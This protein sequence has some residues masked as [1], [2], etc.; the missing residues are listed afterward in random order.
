MDFKLPTQHL[1]GF[2]ERNHE[3]KLSEGS[4]TMWASG[5]QPSYD[6]GTGFKQSY[7]VHPFLLVKARNSTKSNEY[8][9][10]FFR[11]VNG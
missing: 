7:G 8:F 11:N 10:M 3:F 6:D 5:Q 1:F 9:G 2:G 4:W